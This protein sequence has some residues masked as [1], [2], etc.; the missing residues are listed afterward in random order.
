MNIL[1]VSDQFLHGG[2]EEQII[3][4]VKIL[5]KCHKFSFVFAKYATRDYLKKYNVYRGLKFGPT[6]S[7]GDVV[8]DV[9]KLCEIIK[10]ESIDIIEVHPFYAFLPVMIAANKCGIPVIH[11]IH[12]AP[13]I[14][15][16]TRLSALMLHRFFIA[17]FVPC[18]M[19]PNCLFDYVLRGQYNVREL[20]FAPNTVGVSRYA[21]VRYDPKGKF[22]LFSRLDEDKYIQ[23]KKAIDCAKM[24]NL[25]IDIYG[26]GSHLSKLKNYVKEK[27]IENQVEFKG[28]AYDV[29]RILREGSYAGVMGGSRVALEGLAADLPTLLIGWDKISGFIDIEMYNTIKR[30]NVSNRSLREIT[31]DE[32]RFQYEKLQKNPT[33]FRL[34]GLVKK[35]FDNGVLMNIFKN[36]FDIAFRENRYFNILDMLYDELG[37]MTAKRKNEV[38]FD[39][40]LVNKIL[41]KL[42][43]SQF[44]VDP[45]VV[46]LLIQQRLQKELAMLR[47]ALNAS[48]DYINNMQKQLNEISARLIILEDKNLQDGNG[49]GDGVLKR[50]IRKIARWCARFGFI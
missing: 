19:T 45:L 33:Q 40:E 9:D 25:R 10:K 42:F 47:G 7:I 36:A 6:M 21:G 18:V 3:N 13:S 48:N 30:F 31:E 15:F 8:D 23:I 38:F 24:L 17:E 22:V 32:L 46:D 35:D 14:V 4:H 27:G 5:E 49:H 20:I 28:W 26:K 50:G 29:P 2:L 41:D 12:G 37:G 39:S 1:I 44:V 11:I 16:D 34:R 43:I